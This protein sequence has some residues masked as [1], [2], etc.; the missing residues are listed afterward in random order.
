MGISVENSM[1]IATEATVS[2]WLKLDLRTNESPGWEKAIDI[3]RDRIVG[4]FIE[5]ADI[6]IGIDSKRKRS[7]RT[8]GF[9]ILAIDCML[10]ETLIKFMQVDVNSNNTLHHFTNF[11]LNMRPFRWTYNEAKVFYIDFR[12]GI[13]HDAEIDGSSLVRSTG[14]MMIYDKSTGSLIINRTKFH[15]AINEVFEGYITDLKHKQ[16]SNLRNAFKLKMDDICRNNEVSR[17]H[18]HEEDPD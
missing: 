17:R 11:L 9:A 8:Y 10:I 13:L 7:K 5:P 18:P 14:K 1:T 12:C 3:F 16:N 6:L 15:K 4:R 2:D